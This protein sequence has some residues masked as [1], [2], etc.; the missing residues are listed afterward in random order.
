MIRAQIHL[1]QRP[2]IRPVQDQVGRIQHPIDGSLL[3][4]AK[5]TVLFLVNL[6][7]FTQHI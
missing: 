1:V 4:F 7:G 2:V 3:A 6:L 5:F